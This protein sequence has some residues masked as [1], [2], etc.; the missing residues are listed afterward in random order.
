MDSGITTS[1]IAGLLL[2][3]ALAGCTTPGSDGAA[4]GAERP[5]P[6]SSTHARVA[7]EVGTPNIVVVMADDMR[8]DD[9][10][11]MPRVRRE[12]GR[13]GLRFQNSF[14]A[15]PLCCPARASFLTG[16]YPHNHGTLSNRAPLG[17]FASFDDRRTLATSLQAVGYRTA[18]VGKYLNEYGWD[19]SRTGHSTSLHYVPPGWTDWYATVDGPRGGRAQGGTYDYFDPVF[20]INGHLHSHLTG[21]YE[22]DLLGRLAR[23]LI[24]RYARSSK[25]FFLF[26]TPLAPH[27]GFPIEEDDRFVT[28]GPVGFMRRMETPARPR[29]VRG[30]LD[31]E[32]TRSPGLPPGRRGPEPDV[33]D[34]PPFLRLPP[35]KAF[36]RRALL[37]L[38]RQRAEALHVLDLE[39]G[40][41]L[42]TMRRRGLL[43]NTVVVFT[44]DNGYFLGEHRIRWAKTLPYE[45]AVRVPLLISGPGIPRGNRFG[46]VQ[47]LDLTRTILDLAHARPP[48]PQDGTSV[49]PR[50][51]RDSGWTVPLVAEGVAQQTFPGPGPAPGFPDARNVIAVRTARYQLVRWASG[52]VE[53]YDL[54]RDPEQLVNRAGDPRYHRT[55]GVLTR[56]WWRTKDCEGGECTRPLPA[57]MRVDATRLRALTRTMARRV[58]AWSGVSW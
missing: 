56:I 32:V 13:Q 44:S 6:A 54:L 26:V 4:R 15:Y 10:R 31:D 46:P 47:T 11:F 50:F 18:L 53:L 20:N 29:W 12:I 24:R 9:L 19:P 23:G 48:H 55:L 49:V 14:T 51:T 36:E 16:Q 5:S 33:S 41:L 3:A 21:E 2:L 25:P 35:L 58:R 38:T 57:S 30:D 22:T 17:G 8:A 39:V 34:K 28:R 40:R 1:R 27:T 45:P 43:D 7:H 42:T 37:N 52:D